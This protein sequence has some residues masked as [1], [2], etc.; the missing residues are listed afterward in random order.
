MEQNMYS[1]DET[2]LLINEFWIVFARRCE[3]VP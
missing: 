2:N 1:K 3:T